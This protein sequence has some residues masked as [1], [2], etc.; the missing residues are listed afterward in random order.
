MNPKIH[1]IILNWNG[2]SDTLECLES[3]RK[4][5][6]DNY[7]VVVVDNNSSGDDVKIIKEK[8]GDFVKEIIVAKDNLGFSGGNNLGIKYSLNNSTDFILLLNNDTVVEPDFLGKLLDSFGSNE[9]VGIAAPKI[10]YYDN[11]DIVWTAGGKISK[12][13]GSG[14]AYSDKKESEIENKEKVVTFAS[15]CCLLI[16]REVFE[17]AGF[18]D[19]KFFLYVEDTDFCY[20]TV[21]AGYKIIVSPHSKIFH[22][23]GRSVSID[24]KQLP[25]YYTTRNRLF[26]AKKNFYGFHLITTIYIFTTMLY[27]TFFWMIKGK[28]KNITAV[29]NA[30]HDFFRDNMGKTNT[31]ELL[32]NK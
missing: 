19:E 20:R 9:N 2:F 6:Y 15:G 5:E 26:F 8:F 31:E 12:I 1:I 17:K 29:K 18:F 13:R 28:T 7:D 30:F 23:I 14:F 25:L 4:I 27:K 10:N 32:V 11:P 22:K 21:K 16:K 3:L 24:L